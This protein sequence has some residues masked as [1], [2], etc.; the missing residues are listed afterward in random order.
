MSNFFDG[1]NSY[2]DSYS[3]FDSYMRT[4]SANGSSS[5]LSSSIM[6][7]QMIKNGSYKKALKAYYAKNPVKKSE[8]SKESIKDSGKADS[9]AN[10][11]T[12]KSASQK[13]NESVAKLQKTDY[14]KVES[15]EDMLE[16]VKSLVSSYNSTVNAAKNLNSYSI[17]QTTLWMTG[18]VS[19]SS[20]ILGKMGISIN[21]DNTLSLDEDKFKN[22]Q[23]STI[24]SAFSSGV[25]FASRLSQKATSLSNQSANQIAVNT[26]KKTYTSSGT[27]KY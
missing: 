19:K 13:L 21:E 5:M 3:F 14:S 15:P 7:L 16:D 12:M 25:S 20:G 24:K 18:N 27:I 10:L 4:G 17:L 9:A 23:M 1:V 2:S 11:S 8:D 6:D 26:G 22:A